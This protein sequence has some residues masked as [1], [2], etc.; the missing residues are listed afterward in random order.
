MFT[1]IDKAISRYVSFSTEELDLFHSVL[2]YRKV[3]KKTVLLR[4][5]DECPFEAFVIRGCIRKYCIDAQGTEV[6]L[7]FA[8]EESWVGD[9]SFTSEDPK[10]SQVFIE[11]LEECVSYWNW[12][13]K[14]KKPSL[15]KRPVLNA[16]S[17][18]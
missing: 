15:K 6:T 16:P 5:G 12:R 9:I 2:L 18:S 7:Q 1:A 10:P 14:R 8:V 3:P 4:A 13:R 11:T 17:V